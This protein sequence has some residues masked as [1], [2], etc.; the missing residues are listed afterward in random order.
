[1]K[2]NALI[3]LHEYALAV[4]S[5]VKLQAVNLDYRLIHIWDDLHLRSKDY[6]LK[7]LAFIYQTL[8][9]L[10]IDIIAGETADVL[11]SQPEAS[12]FI[13]ETVDTFVQQVADVLTSGGKQ[14]QWI[15]MTPFVHMRRQKVSSR[16]FNYWKQ[17]EKTAFLQNAGS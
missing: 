12:I 14:V 6:S 1:M 2:S 4:P 13:P 8:I 7:R 3:W 10:P 15:E 17:A 16:F 9:T 11:F 5:N